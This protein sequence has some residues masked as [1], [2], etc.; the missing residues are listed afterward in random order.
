MQIVNQQ[1][2]VER[3]IQQAARLKTAAR[4]FFGV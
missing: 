1:Q 2:I 4:T 3:F